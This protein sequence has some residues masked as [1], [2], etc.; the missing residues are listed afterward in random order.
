MKILH[1]TQGYYPSIGGT[2]WMIQRV[3]EELVSQFGDEVTV[4]STNCYNGEGFLN[5]KLP[6]LPVGESVINGVTIRRFPVRSRVS[7]FL[8][9]LQRIAYLSH[10]PFN[11]YLRAWAQGP[12]VPGLKK[13]IREFDADVIGSSS[14]PLMHMFVSLQAARETGRPCIFMGA[15][16]PDDDWGFDRAM[17][18]KAIQQ[19]TE[20][21]AYTN[22]EADYVIRKGADPRRIH[23]IGLGVDPEPYQCISQTEARLHFGLGE[24]PIVG[25]IG[26]VTGHKLEL[27]LRAFPLV[28]EKIPEAILLIAGSRTA[29]HTKFVS[30]ITSWPKKYRQKLKLIYN[31]DEREKPWLFSAMDVF[32]YP[33][34]W[35]SFGLVFLEAWAAK[36]PVIACSRG[37]IPCVVNAGRD[38]LLVNF[39]NHEMLSEAIILLLNNP[40][41]AH[42]FGEVGQN[43]VLNTYTWGQVAQRFRKVYE[44]GL[45]H[46][47]V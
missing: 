16:H 36:K 10:L 43:K 24:G 27:L 17:I 18:Y 28:W 2:E 41:L 46:L 25:Y 20:Y 23:V 33:S 12:L 34:A 35:E 7:H 9:K 32:A 21:I 37:A 47:K 30:I 5:P 26:Q 4:F 42:A 40:D 39:G 3:S 44:I 8:W 22:Y 6:R 15:L 29:Y 19:S 13:S 31:F 38:G 11:Q 14:F 1:V 45:N